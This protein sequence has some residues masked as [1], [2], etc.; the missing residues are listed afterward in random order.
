MQPDD[1]ASAI[2]VGGYGDYCR[3]LHASRST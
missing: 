2:G 3:D 1:L